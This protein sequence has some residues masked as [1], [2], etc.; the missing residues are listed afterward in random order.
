MQVVLFSFL[1]VITESFKLYRSIND[2][3]LNML[4]KFFETDAVVA[5]QVSE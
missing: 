4:D 1:M 5:Q 3:V 2:G